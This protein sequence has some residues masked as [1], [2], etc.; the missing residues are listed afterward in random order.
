MNMKELPSLEPEDTGMNWGHLTSVEEYKKFLGLGHELFTRMLNPNTISTM[1]ET[2]LG[3]LRS[4]TREGLHGY[5]TNNPLATGTALAGCDVNRMYPTVL[6]C[7]WFPACTVF[8]QFVP[9]PEFQDS[10]EVRGYFDSVLQEHHL[11]LVFVETTETSAPPMCY[12]DRGMAL[13]F[14]CNLVKFLARP[15]VHLIPSSASPPTPGS[16][17]GAVHVRLIAHLPTQRVNHKAWSVVEKVS[18]SKRLIDP[19]ERKSL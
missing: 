12:V 1:N 14:K 7:G 5:L 17:S 4:F 19:C 2:V 10:A 13:C 6:R 18:T 15:R 3:I 16:E 11:C 8:D 9:T